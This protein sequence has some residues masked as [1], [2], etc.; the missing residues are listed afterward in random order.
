MTDI[1]SIPGAKELGEQALRDLYAN[2]TQAKGFVIDQA[3][4]FCQ[5]LIVRDIAKHASAALI[6]GILFL[7]AIPFFL[8]CYRHKPTSTWDETRGLGCS[9]I[10]V[11]MVGL[12]IPTCLCSVQALCIYL[13]PKVYLVEQ[14]AKMIK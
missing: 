3:P 6:C 8:K 1:E 11:A 14:I 13:A 5:Q 2:L 7:I 4:E 10:G 9:L 12:L